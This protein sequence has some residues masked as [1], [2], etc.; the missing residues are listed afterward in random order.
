MSVKFTTTADSGSTANLL[1]YGRSGIGKTVLAATA[2]KPIIISS[3]R[4]LMSIAEYDIPVMEVSTLED[5]QE[6]YDYILTNSKKYKTVVLDS[7]SDI[8]ES[9]L[10]DLL[11]NAR[12]PRK[13]YGTLN[14]EVASLIRKFR[15]LEMN[16]YFIAKAQTYE[17]ASGLQCMRPAMPGQT[18][19]RDLP[20]FFD[21]VLVLRLAE[22]EVDG[23]KSTYRYLQTEPDLTYEAKDRSGKL[24]KVEQPNLKKLFKKI[25]K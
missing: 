21:I 20:Y 23:E 15:D 17:S 10:S 6:A 24:D 16:T 11:K 22:Q 14:S 9:I 4:G 1:I 18:L 25:K 3:E 2:P 12:D 5:F 7:I 8:A 19:V 13:A